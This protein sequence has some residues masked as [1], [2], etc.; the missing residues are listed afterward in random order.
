MFATLDAELAAL[1]R[2][3]LERL[4]TERRF[5]PRT[6]RAYGCDL[7]AFFAF[8]SRHWGGPADRAALSRLAPRD[9]RAWLAERQR[10]GYARS[11]T[12]RA[13]AAVRGFFRFLE[14]Q[15]VLSGAAVRAIRVGGLRRHL[16]RALAPEEAE[17]LLEAAARPEREPWVGLRDRAVLALLWGAGLRIGEALAL[18]R[19]A[20]G[21][22]PAA[23]RALR[24]RGK[25][26]RERV[27]PVL[28]EV[29]EALA[30]YVAACP[31]PLPPEGP[32]FRGV[33]GGA[34][35]PALVQGLLR[36]LRVALGLPE[37]ATP[38]ALRHSFATH[39]LSAGADLRAIQELLGHRS[40]STTQ[41]YTAVDAGRLLALHRTFHP[42]ARESATH[43]RDCPAVPPPLRARPK[44]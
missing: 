21:P 6:V 22:D 36:R 14:H 19:G 29:A 20:L 23:L 4:S 41:R 13:M 38:H 27:V 18:A 39:L 44:D 17:A 5:S 43:A 42:R 8:L 31:W 15:R 34:L 11:S 30:A 32:L 12:V 1:A 9:L 37:T 28:P 35:Q 33:R 26:G 40:L 24:I 16:P 10:R 2:A 25:A 7:E 3:W